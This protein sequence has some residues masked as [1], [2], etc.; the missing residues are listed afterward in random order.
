MRM[1][2]PSGVIK[3]WINVDLVDVLVDLGFNIFSLQRFRLA[4]LGDYITESIDFP[5]FQ[6]KI[7]KIAPINTQVSIE[8]FGDDHCGNWVGNITLPDGSLINDILIQEGI[9]NFIK[10]YR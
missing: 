3:N 8:C 4:G 7:Q 6:E 2:Y 5:V 10:S 1:L 9:S